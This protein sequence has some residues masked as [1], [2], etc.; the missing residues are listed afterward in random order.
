MDAE[1][2]T[3]ALLVLETDVS[4]FEGLIP[5][6]LETMAVFSLYFFPAMAQH[7]MSTTAWILWLR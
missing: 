1:E 2:D 4:A 5:K 3:G 6:P 7:V